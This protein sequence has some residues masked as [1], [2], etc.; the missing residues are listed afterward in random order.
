MRIA[1]SPRLWILTACLLAFSMGHAAASRCLPVK[2]ADAWRSNPLVFLGTVEAVQD[3]A[4]RSPRGGPIG[5]ARLARVRMNAIWKGIPRREPLLVSEIVLPRFTPHLA[6]GETYVF[7]ADSSARGWWI[8]SC[9]RVRR[10]S[11][12]SEDLAALGKSTPVQRIPGRKLRP[13]R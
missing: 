11:D 13:R 1:S 5:R 6:P 10:L 8:D 7:Y 9:S 4:L 2:P 3:T 12:A